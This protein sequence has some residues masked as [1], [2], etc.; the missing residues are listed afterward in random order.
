MKYCGYVFNFLITDPLQTANYT[1]GLIDWLHREVGFQPSQV[2]IAGHSLGAHTAGL[3][4]KY[5]TSGV[6]SRVTGKIL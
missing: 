3:S 1:A 6:V 5:V 4:G 2:H